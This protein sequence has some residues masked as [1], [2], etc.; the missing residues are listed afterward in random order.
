MRL[1]GH[2]H[3]RGSG[4]YYGGRVE[5]S[6]SGEVWFWRG[7][8]AHHFVSVPDELCGAIEAASGLVSYGWGMV[9]VTVGPMRRA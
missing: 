4:G 3:G 1:S 9:P 7:P 6:F 2:W 8:A 5:L